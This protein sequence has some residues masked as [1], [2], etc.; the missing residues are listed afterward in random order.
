MCDKLNLTYQILEIQ[1][2]N[3][4]PFYNMYRKFQMLCLAR[5]QCFWQKIQILTKFWRR[6]FVNKGVVTMTVDAEVGKIKPVQDVNL[7]KF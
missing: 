1:R 6:A 5:A 7:L 3:L 4:Y 2:D